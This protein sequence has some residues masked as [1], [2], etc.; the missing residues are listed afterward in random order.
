MGA[1]T[2]NGAGRDDLRENTRSTTSGS[3][4]FRLED[5]II[6]EE[7]ALEEAEESMVLS[8]RNAVEQ[9][10]TLWATSLLRLKRSID[11]LYSLCEFDSD[12]LTVNQV[13]D[14]L[15]CAHKDFADLNQRLTLQ[16]KLEDA[17]E[18]AEVGGAMELAEEQ[19]G[20]T[21]ITPGGAIAWEVKPPQVGSF[22]P[23]GSGN[24][25]TPSRVPTKKRRDLFASSSVVHQSVVVFVLCPRAACA[26]THPNTQTKN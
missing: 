20:T 5:S 9:A 14:I 1:E 26:Y 3:F 16:Q 10:Q 25:G 21:K 13:Q 19:K 12:S 7:V 15:S 23:R 6:L 24:G 8:P 22:T 17:R 2:Q 11:E 4:R 18:A